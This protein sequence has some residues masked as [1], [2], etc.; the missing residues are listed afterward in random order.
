GWLFNRDL[1]N[2]TPIEFNDDTN[3]IGE[4]A[5][6]VLPISSTEGPRK[7]IGEYFA[8]TPIADIN[9]FSYDF[10]IGD[11][12]EN[13]DKNQF[14]LNVYANFGDS[15]GNKYYDCKYDIVPTT[16]STSGFTTVTFDPTE[17]YSVQQSGT[18]IHA[19]PASPADMD[20]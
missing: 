13:S 5:L 11:E 19:C 4:G 16:G 12:G 1:N 18:S 20:T 14:Y 3:S 9:S 17:N 10:N 7:F 6:Y 15:A 8:M 2:A